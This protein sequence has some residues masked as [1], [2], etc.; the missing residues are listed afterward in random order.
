M[1]TSRHFFNLKVSTTVTQNA[2][3]LTQC[4]WE[5]Q[6]VGGGVLQ[7]TEHVIQPRR[8]RSAHLSGL[9]QPEGRHGGVRQTLQLIQSS[10]QTVHH[11]QLHVVQGQEEGVLQVTHHLRT[12]RP[13][14]VNGDSPN[15][16]SEQH[17][18]LLSLFW[19]LV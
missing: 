9:Q 11:P 12:R 15:T 1:K 8:R 17:A 13:H 5:G 6:V 4:G 2:P 3:V 10:V 16:C 14:L 18:H 7:T 19:K